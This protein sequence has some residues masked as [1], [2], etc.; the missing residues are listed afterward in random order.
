MTPAIGPGREMK[1]MTKTETRY[2]TVY[3]K[4]LAAR[5]KV[6]ILSPFEMEAL[7][8]MNEYERVSE[9]I[10]Q[11]I[12]DP[13]EFMKQLTAALGSDLVSIMVD[14]TQEPFVEKLH[15][16]KTELLD[17]ACQVNELAHLDFKR[18]EAIDVN[19]GH[20]EISIGP[21]GTLMISAVTPSCGGRGGCSGK[22]EE[23]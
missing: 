16:I 15:R 18:Q 20:C 12:Y 2:Q 9:F 3:V 13:V 5:V 21:D 19:T 4:S 14:S 8:S 7:E 6:R 10:L 11:G 17:A 1:A 23:C 22:C